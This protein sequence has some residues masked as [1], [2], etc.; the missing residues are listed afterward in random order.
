LPDDVA[1]LAQVFPVLRRV[2]AI[3][4]RVDGAAQSDPVER[5]QRTFEALR[6]LLERLG[7]RRPLVVY[8]DDLQWGDVDSASALLRLLEPPLPPLV[9]LAT[10]R[11]DE[12]DTSPLLASLLSPG[13]GLSPEHTLRVAVHRL[14]MSH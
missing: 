8:V 9:F 6:E 3:A 14:S 5:R 11:S 1:T 4:T 7:R 13:S 10:Y 12:V 2:E